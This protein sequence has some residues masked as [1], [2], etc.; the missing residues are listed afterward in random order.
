MAQVKSRKSSRRVL[1]VEPDYKNKYPPLGLMKLATYHRNRGDNVRFFK[2][3]LT[4]LVTD[5]YADEAIKQ[6]NLID[7]STDWLS[8]KLIIKQAIHYGH[9]SAI[10]QLSQLN[11]FVSP[12]I[13]SWIKYFFKAY[14]SGKTLDCATWDRIC[15]T[16][17]F[18]FHFK[19]TVDTIEYCKKLLAPSGRLL[20]GGVMASLIPDEV[21]EATGI[22]PLTGLLDKPGILDTEDQTIIDSLPLDYS[23]LEE[24]DYQYPERDAY[25]GYTSRGCI[26]HCEFC[27]VP[28]LEPVFKDFLPIADLLK[29]TDE[30]FGSRQNLLLLD[31][32]VLA[33]KKF[34]EIIEEIRN[35]GF[36]KGAEFEPPNYLNLAISHLKKGFNVLA[37]RRSAH[38]MVFELRR[39]L[40]GETLQLYNQLL[41]VHEINEFVVPS[42]EQLI[43]LHEDIGELYEE[44]RSK[45]P[46]KR[47]VDFNQGVDARLLTDEK[48]RLLST[49]PIRPLRIAFDSMKYARFYERALRYAAK[50]GIRHLSNYLLYNFNDEPIDLYRRMR[51]NVDL[52]VELDLQIYSFPMRYSPIWDD[53]G[54]HKSRNYIGPRWNKKFIRAVQTVLNATKGKVGTKLSFFNAAFGINEDEFF[55]ILYM[56]ES[57]IF[58]RELFKHNGLAN[59]WRSLYHSLSDDERSTVLPIVESNHFELDSKF[60][61]E[62]LLTFIDHYKPEI[63]EHLNSANFANELQARSMRFISNQLLPL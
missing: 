35:C 45:H 63:F 4:K 18:T 9:V 58:N 47:F 62:K 43:T 20:V 34:P 56:P 36:T 5:L 46:K 51:L 50:Y 22:K 40:A 23:I 10:D 2:G 31:N 8:H 32:N 60:T 21:E 52:S 33:S 29:Q 39:H 57:Y 13:T 38:K 11:P 1:L 3:E 26:R 61:D 55:E 24:I 49:I 19:K 44:R 25:Y 53:N 12:V 37:Y 27:A 28:V 15:V 30:I 54:L 42:A 59:S 16:S 7:S 41:E 17:L 48:M 14:R 6:F